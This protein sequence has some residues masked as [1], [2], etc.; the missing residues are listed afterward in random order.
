MNSISVLTAFTVWC[1]GSRTTFCML[2]WAIRRRLNRKWR[3]CGPERNQ[4]GVKRHLLD[5]YKGI[6][7]A[8]CYLVSDL[9][10]VFRCVYWWQEDEICKLAVSHH[11]HGIVPCSHYFTSHMLV[12]DL[13]TGMCAAYWQVRSVLTFVPCTHICALNFS[14]SWFSISPFQVSC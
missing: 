13:R 1:L 6:H 8:F 14:C 3:A 11:V 10:A 4:S 9:G 5:T 7:C 12:S 2:G